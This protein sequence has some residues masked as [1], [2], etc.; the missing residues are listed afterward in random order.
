MTAERGPAKVVVDGDG[1]AADLSPGFHAF[2]MAGGIPC[3]PAPGRVWV[4]RS[5]WR[6]GVARCLLWTDLMEEGA[7]ARE[8]F[9]RVT[10]ARPGWF[11]VLVLME[12]RAAVTAMEQSLF[13]PAEE[14]PPGRT[15]E[16]LARHLVHA[17][18]AVGPGVVVVAEAVPYEGAPG[19]YTVRVSHAAPDALSADQRQCLEAAP[20]S[21]RTDSAT[22]ILI[23]LQRPGQPV[24]MRG[25]SFC[26]TSVVEGGAAPSPDIAARYL[27]GGYPCPAPPGHLWV[28][29]GAGGPV[30]VPWTKVPS[31]AERFRAQAEDL[32][33]PGFFPVYLHGDEGG[34]EFAVLNRAL[35]LSALGP[36]AVAEELAGILALAG[37]GAWIVSVCY[38]PPEAVAP[39]GLALLA[40]IVDV[41]KGCARALMQVQVNAED[42]IVGAVVIGTTTI[43]PEEG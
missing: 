23:T 5:V 29:Q 26:A 36:E 39:R 38:D 22:Q 1:D 14:S 15:F 40:G 43:D 20:A 21:A 33:A 28:S 2:V 31:V 8:R 6:E 24:L 34:G 4:W 30:C 19:A 35:F 9:E 41:H 17:G 12:E 42:A 25:L 27:A 18:H 7:P 32:L 37:P 3:P 13:R 10:A 16:L 11:P